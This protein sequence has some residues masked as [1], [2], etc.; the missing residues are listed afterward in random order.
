MKYKPFMKLFVFA[1][2]CV[3]VLSCASPA[4]AAIPMGATAERM[5]YNDAYYPNGIYA[6]MTTYDREDVRI[7]IT[8]TQAEHVAGATLTIGVETS[9]TK[10]SQASASLG[11]SFSQSVGASIGVSFAELLEA[12]ADVSFTTTLSTEL[13]VAYEESV[14][15]SSTVSYT[16]GENADPGYYRITTVF[17]SKRVFKTVEGTHVGTGRQVIWT[18]VVECAPRVEMAYY[19]LEAFDPYAD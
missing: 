16:L 17:P 11:C 9:V 18:D 12:S 19:T 10:T 14:T 5:I 6:I 8:S 2:V 7:P 15:V 13:G 4:N 1:V 3:L